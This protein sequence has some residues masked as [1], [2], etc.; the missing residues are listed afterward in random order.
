VNRDFGE[1]LT[2]ASQTAWSFGGL[3]LFNVFYRSA[4][5]SFPHFV[6]ISVTFIQTALG[7]ARLRLTRSVMQQPAL[8]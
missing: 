2:L 6:F 8:Q 7:I 4:W 1:I 3:R 5:F